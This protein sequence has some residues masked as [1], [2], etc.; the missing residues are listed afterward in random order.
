MRLSMKYSE[1][2]DPEYS[3]SPDSELLKKYKINRAF[4]DTSYFINFSSWQI[5]ASSNRAALG[6][7][8]K[9]RISIHREDIN[10][11]WD[12]V[13]PILYQKNIPFKI[14]NPHAIELFKNTRQKKLEALVEEYDLFLEDAHSQ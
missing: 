13:L 6:T 2:I 10:D 3:M 1:L 5:R 7:N 8:W 12:V 4:Y 14:A 9:A 11:A